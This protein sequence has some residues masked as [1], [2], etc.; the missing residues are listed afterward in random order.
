MNSDKIAII[1]SAGKQSRFKNSLPKCLQIIDNSNTSVLDLNISMI[2]AYTNINKIFI[3]YHDSMYNEFK[4]YEE[5]SN[6]V[7]IPIHSQLGCGDATYHTIKKIN[8]IYNVTP[9]TSAILMWGDS[10]QSESCIFKHLNNIQTS[11]TIPLYVPVVYETQP[12]VIIE[13]ESGSNKIS[14]CKFSKFNEQ[15]SSGFHDLSIFL[16]NLKYIFRLLTLMK[17]VSFDSKTKKYDKINSLFPYRNGELLFLDIL[18]AINIA[19]EKCYNLN[20]DILECLNRKAYI[21]D[22][23]SYNVKSRSFN[24]IE[25]LE[26]IRKEINR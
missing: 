17:I 8:S 2:N 25:E 5:L 7:L 15:I 13:V 10:I 4:K 14:G 12:Y 1:L 3:A 26:E 20:E 11:F 22:Y 9:K 23:S 18:N 19:P 21:L 16:L 6:V 24:T